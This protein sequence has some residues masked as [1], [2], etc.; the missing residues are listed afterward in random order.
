[1]T[2]LP[3]PALR[4][5]VASLG[6]ELVFA[7][8]L[9]RRQDGAYE[10]RHANDR[11]RPA[12][13][14]R[15]VPLAGLRELA[16][17]AADGSFRPLKSAPNLRTGWRTLAVTETELGRALDHLYPG[18]VA[19]WFAVQSGAPPLTHYREFTARQTGMYRVT[20][21]LDD[22][23]AGRTTRSCCHRRFCL[24]QRLWTVPGLLPDAIAEKSAVPCLE[25]CAL[26]LEFAAK[27][28]RLEQEEEL[29][30]PVAPGE[31]KTI[32]AALENLLE[33]RAQ[34]VR[35]ADFSETTNPRRLQLLLEK[36]KPLAAQRPAAA[37]SGDP[38]EK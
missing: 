7:Q 35:E 21:L 12:S 36:L 29:P 18:G 28:K 33:H 8:V 22:E 5:F 1:M 30:L 14:L 9:I 20:A 11:A 6:E 23:Q 31:L 19:D 2:A 4:R 37:P 3:H 13:E 10:L 38:E 24:K 17:F 27:V 16:Q 26:L 15:L 34:P 25:P 32:L